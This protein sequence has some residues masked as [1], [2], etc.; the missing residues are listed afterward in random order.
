[1]DQEILI[2]SLGQHIDYLQSIFNW[3][4]ILSVVTAWAGIQRREEVEVL[5]LKIARRY[6]V[7]VICALYLIVNMIVLIIFLRLGNLISLIDDKNFL[8]GLSILVTH[9][10]ILNPFSY[11]GNS[12]LARFYSCEGLGLLIVV[13]WLANASL[14]TLRDDKINNY[15]L[16]L[17]T[18]FLL[19]GLVSMG[20]IF[21]V[22]QIIQKRLE[23]IN[24]DL[25]Q[26]FSS[27]FS[28]ELWASFLGVLVGLLAFVVANKLQKRLILSHKAKS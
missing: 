27:V 18:V 24:P 8:K 12:R 5:G 6:A 1:M 7:Y 23:Y 13:W 11:F 28:Q 17:S 26:A 25:S 10:W 21:N 20:A 14:S 16:L 9:T 19:L 2:Q 22:Y 15:A 3:L 4:I